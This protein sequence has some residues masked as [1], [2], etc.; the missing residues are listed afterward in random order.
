VCGGSDDDDIDHACHQQQNGEREW[1]MECLP[2]SHA[3][4]AGVDEF[5][6]IAE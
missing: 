6:K 5:V 2:D 3:A 1:E 4:V